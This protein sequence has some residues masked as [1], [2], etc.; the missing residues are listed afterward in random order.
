MHIPLRRWNLVSIAVASATILLPST[1]MAQCND[2]VCPGADA[3]TPP[4]PEDC[5]D[6]DVGGDL[7][8]PN[9]PAPCVPEAAGFTFLDNLDGNSGDDQ[10]VA[11]NNASSQGCGTLQVN[12]TGYYRIF[13]IELAESGPSQQD[14]TGYMT[15]TNSCN[16]DGWPIE[17][18]YEDRFLVIDVDNDACS[19]EPECGAGRSCGP[20]DGCIPDEPTFLGTFFLIA[21]EDNT[22]CINHWCPEYDAAVANGDDPGF[23]FNDCGSPGSINSIHFRITEETLAC[24]DEQTLF[25]CSFGC[26]DGECAADPCES[27]GCENFCKDGVC[28]DDNP[29]DGLSC[30][31]GCKNG[32]CLQ[33][34]GSRGDDGDGDG[35]NEY[36]DCDDSNPAINP[37]ADEACRSG[38]DEDC[39]GMVDEDDCSSDAPGAGDASD[40]G[41]CGCDATW[42]AQSGLGALLLSLAIAFRLRRRRRAR[43]GLSSMKRLS[44][45]TSLRS[46]FATVPLNAHASGD[47]N[48]AKKDFGVPSNVQVTFVWPG[49]SSSKE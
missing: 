45:R 43:Q 29:C 9:P 7:C 39:D 49:P 24:E 48:L 36:G 40:S 35:Y 31:Y 3:G 8:N 4:P 17:R 46:I 6:D 47:I 22:I 25:P 28:T 12:T 27:A 11:L 37:G 18:N 32:Y 16:G 5:W 14:E 26:F 38:A 34:P 23:V 21:G 33:G 20:A 13:D 15:I 10:I 42:T 30:Q 41:G 1:G 44:S 2:D 19:S